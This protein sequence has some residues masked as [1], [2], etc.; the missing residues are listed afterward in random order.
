[1]NKAGF[2]AVGV[3]LGVILLGPPSAHA[4]MKCY[5]HTVVRPNQYSNIAS[6]SGGSQVRV[7]SVEVRGGTGH[8]DIIDSPNGLGT[9]SS[10]IFIAEP[11]TDG[12]AS[13]STGRIDTLCQ[14]GLA[15]ESSNV[16]VVIHW[17]A[18]DR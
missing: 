14:F 17:D 1:M 8:A 18:V 13:R 4:E 6:N 12:A 9:S 3:A 7:C 10:A 11:G 15:V 5:R 2:I 16:T